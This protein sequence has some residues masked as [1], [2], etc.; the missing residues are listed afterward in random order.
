MNLLN[1][2][3][4]LAL[5]IGAVLMSGLMIIFFWLATL[6]GMVFIPMMT[7]GK[8]RLSTVNG[9]TFELQKINADG[10][11]WESV[12]D[13][14]VKITPVDSS[15]EWKLS[16]WGLENMMTG[17]TVPLSFLRIE[18]DGIFVSTSDGIEYFVSQKSIKNFY[19]IVNRN[20]IN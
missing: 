8:F 5:L 12:G 7:F 1:G 16:T 17:E 10:Q 20:E 19:E 14:P 3:F 13:K 18:S 6:L 4:Q 15:F 2:I 11:S 9:K